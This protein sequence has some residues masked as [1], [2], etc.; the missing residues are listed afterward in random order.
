VSI[1]GLGDPWPEHVVKEAA[2]Q[3]RKEIDRRRMEYVRSLVVNELVAARQRGT[4][5]KVTK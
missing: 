3:L 1:E 5:N 4:K 2:D